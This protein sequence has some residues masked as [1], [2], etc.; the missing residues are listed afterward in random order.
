MRRFHARSRA[1][2][3]NMAGK[4]G[5]DSSTLSYGLPSSMVREGAFGASWNSIR[6]QKSAHDP[7]AAEID[8]TVEEKIINEEYKIWKKNTPFLFATFAP[9]S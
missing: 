2:R 8:G 5:L 1:R 6:N 9:V 4:E 3:L 7:A